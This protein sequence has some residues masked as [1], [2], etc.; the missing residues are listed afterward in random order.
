MRGVVVLREAMIRETDI[1]GRSARARF[2][3]DKELKRL[4]MVETDRLSGNQKRREE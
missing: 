4:K 1:N 2:G 3:D